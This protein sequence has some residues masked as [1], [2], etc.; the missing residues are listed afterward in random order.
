MFCGGQ[1]LTCQAIK[2]CQT[3]AA[4]L[5]S[6]KILEMLES[7][8]SKLM[9]VIISDS[10]KPWLALAETAWNTLV[11]FH[12]KIL[13]TSVFS[14]LI[15]NENWNSLKSMNHNLL[16]NNSRGW[17]PSVLDRNLEWLWSIPG[18]SSDSILVPF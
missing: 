9:K 6:F 18:Q 2:Y 14:L 10:A 4:P 12:L 13:L 17:T 16:R 1:S 15:S 8:R 7:I 11:W 3:N 5:I